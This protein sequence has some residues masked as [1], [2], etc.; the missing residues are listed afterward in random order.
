MSNYN[1]VGL[2]HTADEAKIGALLKAIF[3]GMHKIPV[4]PYGQQQ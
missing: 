2:Y 3:R 1:I 4:H